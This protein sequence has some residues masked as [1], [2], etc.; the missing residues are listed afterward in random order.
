MFQ[1]LFYAVRPAHVDG[2]GAH[3]G[4]IV[5]REHMHAVPPSA[6]SKMARDIGFRHHFPG[7]HGA[8]VDHRYTDGT[9]DVDRAPFVMEYI[10]CELMTE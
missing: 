5:R 6:F 9:A 1:S 4:S 10:V 3:I 2:H 7:G 8:C